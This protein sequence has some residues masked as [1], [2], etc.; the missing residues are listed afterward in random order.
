MVIRGAA[1]HA[2]MRV[3]EG[4]CLFLVPK[5]SSALAV[6]AVRKQGP[7]RPPIE[8]RSSRSVDLILR[9]RIIIGGIGVLVVLVVCS[10]SFFHIAA[11]CRCET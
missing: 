9:Y 3:L 11:V 7:G 5:I 8:C 4:C 1:E 10:A 2:A 6:K